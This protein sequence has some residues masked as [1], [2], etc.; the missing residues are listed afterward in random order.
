MNTYE[1]PLLDAKGL[2]VMRKALR[3]S[4]KWAWRPDVARY[5]C[6]VALPRS[7]Q[8][9]IWYRHRYEHHEEGLYISM[10]KVSQ[11]AKRWLVSRTFQRPISLRRNT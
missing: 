9:L 7:H 1:L 5:G 10:D 6:F 11:S 2:I 8:L 4:A 3:N